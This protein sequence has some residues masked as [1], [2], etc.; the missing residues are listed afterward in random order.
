MSGSDGRSPGTRNENRDEQDRRRGRSVSQNGLFTTGEAAEIKEFLEDKIQIVHVTGDTFRSGGNL[1]NGHTDDRGN[2]RITSDDQIGFGGKVTKFNNNFEAISIL[3]KL[4]EEGRKANPDEQSKLVLYTGWGGLAE[5]FHLTPTPEWKERQDK[6]RALLTKEEYLSAERSTINAHYTSTEVVNKIWDIVLKLGYNG[7]PTLEPACGTGL[8]FGSRPSGVPVEMHGI[9]LDS[10]SGRIARQLYQSASIQIAGYETIRMPENTYNLIISNV[11]FAD[12]KPYEDRNVRTPGIETNKYSLHDFYFLKSLYGLREGGVIAFVTS[13]YTMDKQDDEVR[14]KIAESADL[15]GAFRLPDIAFKGIAGTEVITDILFLQK[16]NP[17]KEM[18][19]LTKSFLDLSPVNIT[20]PDGTQKEI[21]INNYYTLHPEMILGDNGLTG[22]MYTKYDYNVTSDSGVFQEALKKVDQFFPSGIMNVIIDKRIEEMTRSVPISFDRLE[23]L[24]VGM[25]AVG[26]DGKVYYKDSYTGQVKLH[27]FYDNQTKNSK[28][29][30]K[31]LRMIDIRDT[32]LKAIDSFYN[33]NTVASKESVNRLNRIYDSFVIKYGYLND[34]ANKKSFFEDPYASLLLS[35]EK[36]EEATGNILKSDIFNG[37]AFQRKD[38]ITKA[39][40]SRDSMLLSLSRYGKLDFDYMSSLTGEPKE[41]I[42]KELRDTGYIYPDPEEYLASGRVIYR[43]AEEYLSGNVRE[44]LRLSEKACLKDRDEFGPNVDA[45]KKVVPADIAPEDIFIKLSSPIVGAN[46]VEQFIRDLL[47]PDMYNPEGLRVNVVHLTEIGKWEV[48]ISG[49]SP[50]VLEG[51]YG[52]TRMPFDKV[53]NHILNGTP[54]KVLDWEG[55]GK[56]RTSKPNPDAT[57][58]AELKVEAVNTKFMEWIWQSPERTQ[59]IVTRYNEVFNSYVERKYIHPERILNPKATI[60]FHGCA[61]PHP[62]RSNQSDAV[63]RQLQAKNTMLAHSVGAGKTLEIIIAV[64]ERRR[65]G[66]SNK[67]MIVVPDHLIDQW[68]KAFRQAYPSAKVLVADDMNWN[69]N[70]R[71]TFI[72]KIVTGDWDCIII[73]QHSFIK[74][75]MS[76]AYQKEFF[77]NKIGEYRN[78]LESL[79]RQDGSDR[80]RKNIEDKILKYE[81]KI[82]SLADVKRDTGVLEFEKLGI[83]YLAID[84]A[85]IFKNL[86]FTTQLENV[87]GLGTKT[88]SERALDMYMKVKFIQSIDGGITFATGTPVSN[89]L[90]EAYTMQRF[91]QPEV[92][93][94]RGIEAFDEWHRMFAETTQQLELNNSGTNYKAVTRFSR[95][96]NLPE[97]LTSLRMTWDIRTA[98][99]LED[100]GI[101]VQGVNLPVMHVKNVDAP[102]T[103]ILKSYLRFLQKREEDL[104]KSKKTNKSVPFKAKQDNVLSIITDGK[105]ASVDMRLINPALPDHPQSKLNKAVEIIYTAYKEHED[106]RLTTAVFFEKPRAFEEDENTG[107]KTLLFDGV[108]DIIKKLIDKGVKPEE[109]GDIRD[110]D[111]YEEKQELFEKVNEGKVRVIF[112]SAESMGAGTNMQ[113][114][115]KTLIHVDAPWRPRDVEQENGRALRPGNTNKDIEV[116]NLVTKGSID[117]GL[118][119]ILDVKSKAISQIMSGGDNASRDMEEE[120]YGSVKELSIENPILKE[121]VE[122]DT[123]LKKLRHQEKGFLSEKGHAINKINQLMNG[124]TGIKYREKII[125]AI[126]YDIENRPEKKNDK[127][128]DIYRIDIKGTVHTERKNAGT[129]LIMIADRLFQ[130][131]KRSGSTESEVIG[132]YL[133]HSLEITANTF[134]SEDIPDHKADILVY[135][136]SD[137]EIFYKVGIHSKSD[138]VGITT[139]LS[140]LIYNR[141][142][143]DLQKQK[144][145]IQKNMNEIENYKKLSESEFPKAQELQTKQ[146]RYT[147]VM[148]LLNAEKSKRG[149]EKLYEHDI[150][151]EILNQ[152]DSDSIKECVHEY[153]NEFYGSKTPRIDLGESENKQKDLG[154]DSP[155]ISIN[156]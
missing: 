7:G 9:E 96:G 69:G 46:H 38:H 28:N 103:P 131:S 93:R 19:E 12:I 152:L 116:Y 47:T 39:D 66:L 34:L 98:Q 138:I 70:K 129:Q 17:E 58:E 118:W 24:T 95:I 156:M 83:D 127:G 54:V 84:E 6:L 146:E 150:P 5:V 8:F 108:K 52:T 100:E 113:R 44:K 36:T 134:F 2:Y 142:E 92:L 53:I 62:L 85:D 112:G 122:L 74:I 149:P 106:K 124:F 102:S 1:R 71:K 21:L 29:I 144:T 94:A 137:P 72:N 87:R 48:K 91:L 140:N 75:P 105:K 110:Y 27:E 88:G 155:G 107:S 13:R 90:V 76:E 33:D 79:D 68:G 145:E 78:M 133:G 153:L 120:Y 82:K 86:E 128:E 135:S 61:F 136:K 41:N 30:D 26:D 73:R 14:R 37:V 119:N 65:L 111:T 3:K 22:K 67:P 23:K 63:W 99:N 49:V 43:P 55:S 125:K 126:E 60:N 35:L 121:A 32:T 104:E 18:S 77:E 130:K 132:E 117:T 80:T 45:L 114:H 31:L 154:C 151:W 123:S 141:L 115:L 97:L 64:M 11:P 56:N 143:T 20:H 10:L 148:S 139:S 4:E 57:A 89:T 81:Q 16:R 25:H 51:K 109:I 59:D 50:S 40:S 147:E 42:V 101:L 15:I